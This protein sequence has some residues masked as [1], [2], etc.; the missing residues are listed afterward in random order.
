MSQTPLYEGQQEP[1]L[2]D[3]IR[4]SCRVW[5]RLG[6]I[7]GNRFFRRKVQKKKE[8]IKRLIF[9]CSGN[10]CRSPYADWRAKQILADI[11]IC[12]AGLHAE[13]GDPA[14]PM[15][16]AVSKRFGVDLSPH[17][18]RRFS[19]FEVGEGDLILVKDGYHVQYISRLGPEVAQRTVLLGSFCR[20]KKYPLIVADPWSQGEA[21]FEFCYKQ[22]EDALIGLRD[23]V[24]ENNRELRG[25]R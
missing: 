17:R 13:E 11:E 12:S 20:D 25:G 8:I 6:L 24:E 4:R 10:I 5:N 7:L 9:V 16:I 15:A 1:S 23:F 14:D 3:R 19:S 18:T 2:I 21:S 22:I